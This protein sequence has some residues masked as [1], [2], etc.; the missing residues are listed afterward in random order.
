MSKKPKDEPQFED[1]VAQVEAALQQLESGEL[2]LEEALKRYEDGV[3]GLRKCYEILKKA[4]KKVQ[5]LTERQGEVSEKP[6]EVD[7]EAQGEDPKKL[8]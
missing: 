5:L 8:F 7:E 3:A 1:L 6:F 2:P 4:E